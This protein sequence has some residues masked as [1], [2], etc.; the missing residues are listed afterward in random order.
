MNK[1]KKTDIKVGITVIIG[2]TILL[3]TFGWIKN[4]KIADDSNKLRINFN[5]VAGLQIG[6]PVL[7]NGLKE[8]FVESIENKNNNIIVI[9][10]LEKD[11]SLKKD[12]TFGI[13]MLDLMGGKK[14]EIHPGTSEEPLDYSKVQNGKFAGD[15][16][17][18]IAVLS[19][20]QDDLVDVIKEVKISLNNVNELFLNDS[21]FNEAENVLKNMNMLTYKVNKLI[22][23][24]EKD[25]SSLIKS[26]KELTDEAGSVLK[27][28][29]NEV[30][31]LVG[32]ADEMIKSSQQLLDKLNHFASE[33]KGKK[34]NLG[35]MLY[36]EEL[37][38][39]LK[40]S[41]REL[42]NLAEILNKQIKDEGINVDA[43][44]F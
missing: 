32:S 3:L 20:V 2:I 39:D 34:N 12:A 30:K 36:D 44:I 26:T 19:N 24:N 14:I 18:A 16:S 25:I 10:D 40:K 13:L 15:I 6:D 28:N 17:T 8:G 31:S 23:S 4:I 1:N 29:R 35:K 43:N 5:S 7:V 42:K 37:M 38:S 11:I 9:C 41:I 22:E 33:V 21:L 27:E